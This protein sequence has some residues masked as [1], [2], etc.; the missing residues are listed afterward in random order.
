MGEINWK[1][2]Y[3]A[4]LKENKALGNAL[5]KIISLTGKIEDEIFRVEDFI[6][7]NEIPEVPDDMSAIDR[8]I[9]TYVKEEFP[10]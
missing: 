10:R 1:E 7:W 9:H 2:K 5:K 8:F 4:L 3:E 6:D